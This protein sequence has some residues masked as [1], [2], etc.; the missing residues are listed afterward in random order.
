MKILA[1]E[2][3][4]AQP[5]DKASPSASEFWRGTKGA[6]P[7]L[8]G[9]LAYGLVLGAQASQKGFSV[10]EVVPRMTGLNF[11]AGSD[12][13]AI[14]LWSVVPPTLLIVVVTFLVNSRHPIMGA[15][16]RTLCPVA[17]PTLLLWRAPSRRAAGCLCRGA[18]RV[19]ALCL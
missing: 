18:S 1:T 17:P 15:A 6:S 3:L 11:A 9:L 10:V 8:A 7:A 12:F 19:G 13:R 2:H 14:G 16:R 5:A 4:A